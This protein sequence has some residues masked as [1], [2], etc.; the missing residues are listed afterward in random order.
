MA[1]TGNKKI[2]TI[3]LVDHMDQRRKVVMLLLEEHKYEVIEA[4][5]CEEAMQVLA[6]RPV[7]LILTETELPSKSGLFLLK[8]AKETNP[9]IEVILITHNATSY[10]LLQALRLGAYDFIVRPVDTG[11]ILYN[12]VDRALAHI[13]LR[14][15]N[16]QLL[17]ELEENNRN[18]RSSL[19][20]MK[21]LN[22]SIERLANKIDVEDLL[23]ELIASAMREIQA[24]RGFLALFD[25]SGTALRLKMGEGISAE[26]CRR[27]A[28]GIPPGLSTEIVKREKPLLVPGNYPEK[29]KAY[30][31][32]EELEH[33]FVMPGLLAVPLRIKE[34]TVG[35]IA[36]SGCSNRP[37]LGEHDLHFLIQL[38]HHAT[39]AMEK[40]GIIHQLKR[41]KLASPPA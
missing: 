27:Y 10:N 38:A 20:M 40:S 14:R 12:S 15:Q 37:P 4:A 1:A 5:S 11:E 30:V 8:V 26:V 19:K 21:A 39:L 29:M 6:E 3:L 36:L 35:L 9:E 32:E 22:E 28:G 25:K 23:I 34:R 24:Q 33:L 2:D 16:K 31:T 18:L 17:T 13:L 7:T 41:G